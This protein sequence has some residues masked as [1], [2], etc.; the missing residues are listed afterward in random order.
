MLRQEAVGAECGTAAAT[1]RWPTSKSGREAPGRV[2]QGS[3]E[4]TIER[5]RRRP[6]EAEAA[7][8]SGGGV[9]EEEPAGRRAAPMAPFSPFCVLLMPPPPPSGFVML[10]WAL[11]PHVVMHE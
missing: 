10:C 11:T 7:R 6:A 5:E 3:N 9:K 8:R 1:G 2:R 4:R